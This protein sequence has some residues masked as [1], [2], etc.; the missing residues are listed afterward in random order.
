MVPTRIGLAARTGF[1]AW[2]RR[3]LRGK[4][5]Q[6]YLQGGV[7]TSCFIVAIMVRCSKCASFLYTVV[8]S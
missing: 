8:V 3:P 2:L 6:A 5:Y 1:G 7:G 4:K